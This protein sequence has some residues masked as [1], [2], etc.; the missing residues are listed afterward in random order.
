MSYQ[1]YACDL[2]TGRI[3]ES[4]PLTGVSAHRSLRSAGAFKATLQLSGLDPDPV[5]N[6]ARAQSLLDSV[7]PMRST[8]AVVSDG[9]ALGEW[10]INQQPTLSNTLGSADLS[11][12]HIRDYLDWV[13][14]DLPSGGWAAATDQLTIAAFLA[15]QCVAGG[16]PA[17]AVGAGSGIALTVPSI[18]SGVLRTRTTDWTDGKYYTASKMITEMAGN[19]S[20]FDWDVSSALSGQFMTRTLQFGYPMLG[21][22][23]FVDVSSPVVGKPGGSVAQFALSMD[24]TQLATQVIGVGSGAGLARIEYRANNTSLAGYPLRQKVAAFSGVSVLATL[25]ANTDAAAA[26]AASALD[27]PQ[28][29]VLAGIDPATGAQ[30]QPALGSYNPG[31]TVTVYVS[32]AAGLPRGWVGRVRLTDYEI[33][34][35]SVGPE[36]VTWTVELA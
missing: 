15:A 31:D 2:V 18:A 8:V 30:Y 5:V 11:G 24:G 9:V 20:G 3:R 33:A 23:L 16:E 32:P 6:Q 27:P 22:D 7:D 14:P 1:F 4:L 26:A 25:Q 17:S 13:I 19:L 21:H 10:I 34:P 12:T 35:V 29:A 36:F 28:L